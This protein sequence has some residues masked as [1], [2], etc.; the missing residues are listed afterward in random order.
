MSAIT[1]NENSIMLAISDKLVRFKQQVYKLAPNSTD[2]N[3]IRLL[4]MDTA[5]FLAAAQLMIRDQKITSAEHL[6]SAIINMTGLGG[7]LAA[8]GDEDRLRVDQ[9]CAYFYE[10]SMI[11]LQN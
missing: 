9:Y 3:I 4:A 11:L 5:E 6:K 10:I 8:L 7:Q 2:P 1:T